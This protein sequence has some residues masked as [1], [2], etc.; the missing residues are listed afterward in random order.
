VGKHNCTVVSTS[1][2]ELHDSALQVDT[3]QADV[4]QQHLEKPE[5]LLF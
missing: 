5:I 2:E 1:N 4:G 3:L